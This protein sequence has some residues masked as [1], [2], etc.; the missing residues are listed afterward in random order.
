[1]LTT[2]KSTSLIV[3][4]IDSGF[5]KAFKIKI[6]TQHVVIKHGAS[7]MKVFNFSDDKRTNHVILCY[8]CQLCYHCQYHYHCFAGQ[9]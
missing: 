9:D 8:D 5:V 2:Q 7:I 3:Q 1:M 6:S 4:H